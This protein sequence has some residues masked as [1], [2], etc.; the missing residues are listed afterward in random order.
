MPTF[1]MCTRQKWVETRQVQ[2][3]QGPK[4]ERVTWTQ[5]CIPNKTAIGN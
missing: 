4:T 3:T 1:I 2:A 5:G